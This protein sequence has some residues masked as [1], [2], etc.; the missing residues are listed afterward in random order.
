MAGERILIVEDE[1]IVQLHLR[2]IVERLGYQ[3]SGLAR[4]AR[5]AVE[6]A[7]A[8]PPDLI[9]MDIRL[10]GEP[11]GIEATRQILASLAVPVVY[12]TAYADEETLARAG[13]TEPAGYVVKPFTEESVRA[14]LTMALARDHA[15][16]EARE[17]ERWLMTVLESVGDG[18]LIVDALGKVRFLSAATADLLGREMRAVVGQPWQEALGLEEEAQ[19]LLRDMIR[20]PPSERRRVAARLA[21]SAQGERSMEVDVRDDPGDPSQRIFLLFDTSAAEELRRLLREKGQLHGMVGRSPQIQRVFEQIRDV[22]RVE[23]TAL[24]EGETGTG[25]ELVARAIH[26]ASPRSQGPFVPI[27]CAGLTESLVASQLFGHIKG[28]FTGAVSNQRG[29]FEAANGG[30]LFLDEIGDVPAQIQ[31]TLLRVLEDKI[32]TP[33]GS[34]VPRQVDIR[35]VAATHRD[36][37]AEVER[38]RFRADLFYRLRVVCLALPP[39]RERSG[40]LPLLAEWFLDRAR[41]AAAK[42]VELISKSAMERL[43]RHS[44]PGNVRE[45]KSAIDFAVIRC[46]GK[47]IQVSDLPPEIADESAAAAP[48]EGAER[49]LDALR[50]SEGN[51]TRAARLAGISRATFYRR[52]R[53]LGIKQE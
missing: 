5:E 14:T 33:V 36:L 7:R 11:D 51:R 48:F 26:A 38:G 13:A 22:A 2:R 49:L 25:K 20:R 32:V 28:A 42:P 16:R 9:L 41:A 30:T 34:T 37:Q 24:I 40:D 43:R 10:E 4:S 12:L 19:A 15:L 45:L 8:S 46:R 3:V 35:L 6:S 39:L 21:R 31:T 53:E 44:W 50:R 52:L 23:W 27:N 47:E 17:R 29:L 1:N 18:V